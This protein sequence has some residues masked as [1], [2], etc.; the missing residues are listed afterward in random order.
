MKAKRI[1]NVLGYVD[2]RYIE[3]I[4]EQMEVKPRRRSVKRIWLIAAIMALMLLLVGCVAYVLS[5]NDLKLRDDRYTA[6]EMES[7]KFDTVSLQGF[8]GT[9]SYQAAQEWLD[10]EASYDPDGEIMQ[11]LSN[12]EMIMPDEYWSYNCYTPEMTAKVD[13]ICEKYGLNKQGPI[14]TG[15]SLNQFYETIKIDSILRENAEAEAKINPQYLYKTGTFMLSCETK[16]IGENAPWN[17]SI[18]YSLYSV[19]KTDFDDVFLN[20]GDIETYDQ[21]EYTTWNGMQVLL[22]K[23]AEKALV[24][25]D[26]GSAF[27]TINIRNPRVGDVVHGEQMMSWETLE[28]F[29]DTFDFSFEPQP[30]NDEDWEAMQDQLIYNAEAYGQKQE[31]A[32]KSIGCESYAGRVQYLLENA[33]RPEM[34]GYALLDI[35]GDGAEELLIAR[36]QHICCIYTMEGDMTANLLEYPVGRYIYSFLWEVDGMYTSPSPMYLC[37]GNAVACIYKDLNTSRVIYH[38]A[39]PVGGKM[40]WKEEIAWEQNKADAFYYE[41]TM[42]EGSNKG[43]NDICTPISEERYNEILS[44]YVRVKVEWTPLSEYPMG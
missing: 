7:N 41:Y 37:E 24:F 11:S 32:L 14:V 17:Y 43:Y 15:Q 21:W 29:A 8:M 18:E 2:D 23:S 33:S 26:N 38:F 31:E 39:V 16:L 27:I 5:L 35:D 20:V 36:R 1:L 28:A 10:F 30:V 9:P 12:E 13:E 3:E 19:M 42:E 44:S 25:V 4:F 22:A 34:L 40:V 6:S